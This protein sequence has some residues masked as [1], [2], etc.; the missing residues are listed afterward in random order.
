MHLVDDALVIRRTR[1]PI[2]GPI[3]S[4]AVRHHAAVGG[5]GVVTRRA[6]GEPV[7]ARRH[8]NTLGVGVQKELLAVEP[9][10]FGW[11]ERAAR[12][13]S[14]D[15][16]GGKPRNERMPVMPGPLGGRIE[17]DDATRP[18]VLDTIEEQQLDQTGFL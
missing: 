3:I 10:P 17:R 12:P 4:T 13:I 1:W 11:G 8:G 9:Q 7:A 5:R 18:L 6:S 15:L 16:P 14:I 2:V